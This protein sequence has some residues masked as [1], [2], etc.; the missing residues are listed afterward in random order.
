MSN[1]FNHKN[2]PELKHYD[3]GKPGTVN[4]PML[5]PVIRSAYGGIGFASKDKAYQNEGGYATLT[6]AYPAFVTGC[7]PKQRNHCHCREEK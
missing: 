7:N 1:K 4:A 5:G 2:Y 6:Q 3:Q